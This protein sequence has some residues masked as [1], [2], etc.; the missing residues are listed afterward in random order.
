MKPLSKKS[1]LAAILLAQFGFGI[2]FAEDQP[3]SAPA[4]SKMAMKMGGMSEEQKDKNMRMMQEHMLQMH[5]LSDKILAAK[6]PKE[7]DAL[8]EKQLKLMKEHKK[9]HHA[10]MMKMMQMMQKKGAHHKPDDAQGSSDKPAP[11]HQR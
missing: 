11:Y 5:D 6:D 9:A 7:R 10:K 8:K 3:Q 2:C 1:I 4:K